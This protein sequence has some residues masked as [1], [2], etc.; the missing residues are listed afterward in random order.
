MYKQNQYLCK[1]YTHAYRGYGVDMT[2]WNKR[3]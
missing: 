3:H 1:V 2:S